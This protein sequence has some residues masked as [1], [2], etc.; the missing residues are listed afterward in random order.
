M[1]TI[2]NPYVEAFAGATYSA[3]RLLS[4]IMEDLDFLASRREELR[5]DIDYADFLQQ[6][7]ALR[8]ELQPHSAGDEKAA[9]EDRAKRD[10]LLQ[11]IED[12][13]DGIMQTLE[14]TL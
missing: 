10:K 11:R 2:V 3:E 13:I 4:A 1:Q 5:T 9:A 7:E 14:N 12:M 6:L 8:K